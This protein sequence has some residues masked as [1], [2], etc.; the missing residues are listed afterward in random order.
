VTACADPNN[1]C[2]IESFL[3]SDPPLKQVVSQT[4]ETGLRSTQTYGSDQLQWGLGVFCTENIND[5]I[6]VFSNI[7]GRGIF[8]NGGNTL[9][10]GVE[11]N[12]SYKTSSWFSY[13][14]YG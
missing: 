8:E 12:I 1:P 2:L 7:A 9:R 4:W 11:A 14:N 6:T 3:T 13:A 5:I 10:Q